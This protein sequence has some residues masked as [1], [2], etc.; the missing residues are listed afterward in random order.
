MVCNRVAD[1]YVKFI[2]NRTAE[3]NKSASAFLSSQAQQLTKRVEDGEFRLH[4]Y[5]R[6]R[7]MVSLEQ[8]QNLILDR[9]K[10]LDTAL[11]AN[12]TNL[13][14]LQARITQI[15]KASASEEALLLL[16]EISEYQDIS[17]TRNQLKDLMG[18]KS[19]LSLSFLPKHPRMIEI[20]TQI[21]LLKQRLSDSIQMAVAESMNALATVEEERRLLTENL[22]QAEQESLELDK[23]SVEYN[24]IR[25][26]VDN[27]KRMLDQVMDRLTET[28]IST[29]LS[30][31]NFRIL[32]YA[33]P[34]SNPSNLKNE[35]WTVYAA[36]IFFAIVIGLPLGINLLDFK[37]KNTHEVEDILKRPILGE[38]QLLKKEFKDEADQL[39]AT[40]TFYN[41]P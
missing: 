23:L 22:A 41:I 16:P 32:D 33:K 2:V 34:N 13:L 27:N 37:I 5:R 3:S 40:Y 31:S 19:T 11:S 28:E 8:S 12:K 18:Q 7:N 10:H 36:M 29:Q 26:E 17:Q 21:N 25:R 24:L 20:D 9:L 14:S 6:S 39:V 1:E 30:S 4:E 15:K 35:K 38:I